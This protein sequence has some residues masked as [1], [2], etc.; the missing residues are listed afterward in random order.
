M[1]TDYRR[2]EKGEHETERGAQGK[3]HNKLLVSALCSTAPPPGSAATTT[4]GLA[5]T[6][7]VVSAACCIGRTAPPRTCT[8]IVPSG[9]L[10]LATRPSTL[11]SSQQ[12]G[13][14]SRST[15][16]VQDMCLSP[17][18]RSAISPNQTA[19]LFSISKICCNSISKIQNA[20][21]LASTRLSS[22]SSTTGQRLYHRP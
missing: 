8:G 1:S 3:R 7:A 22:V 10:R 13:R 2:A 21:H 14:V 4:S 20:P 11:H 17:G 6:A 16:S 18:V 15:P 12:A 5:L 9:A 19:M